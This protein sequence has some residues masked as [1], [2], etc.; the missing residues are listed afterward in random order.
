MLPHLYKYADV[1]DI[2][3]LIASRPLLIE[4]GVHDQCFPIEP[5]L[6]AHE[7]LKRIYQAAV[8]LDRL[9]ID[10]FAG[11]HQFHG[12]VAFEFF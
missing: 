10:I 12:P 8:A 11:G 9:R 2:A 1:A 6:S 3:G 4:S 7:H 5:V